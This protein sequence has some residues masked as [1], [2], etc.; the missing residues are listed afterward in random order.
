MRGF[1]GTKD[2]SDRRLTQRRRKRFYNIDTWKQVIILFKALF[3]SVSNKLMCL[4]LAIPS[5]E[6]LMFV[7]KA[8]SLP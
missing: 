4:Y 6:C 7:G 2:L 5:S 3:T 8:K 1:P